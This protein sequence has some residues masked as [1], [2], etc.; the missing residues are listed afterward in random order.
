MCCISDTNE[1]CV[2]VRDFYST[3]F[4]I[5]TAKGYLV[6]VAFFLNDMGRQLLSIW[7]T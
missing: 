5:K 4:T 6:A 3:D 7:V 1:L 2:K